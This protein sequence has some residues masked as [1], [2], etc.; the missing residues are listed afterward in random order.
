M[1]DLALAIDS[2][3][4]GVLVIHGD[5]RIARA[6]AGAE[7]LLGAAPGTLA[8]QGLAQLMQG[9][10]SDTV[11]QQT[12]R[13]LARP[14]TLPA[15][16]G[17]ALIR[18][19][20]GRPI[21]L[22]VVANALTGIPGQAGDALV[23]L[24]DVT[25]A[26]ARETLQQK[27]LEAMVRDLPL[28][29]VMTMVCVELERIAP[30]VI[31]S[32]LDV[33]AE[34]RLH[35]LAGPSLP[36]YYAEALDGI[37]CGPTVGSCG[38]S[39][40][41]GE[42]VLV[43]DIANDPLWAP[44]KGLV[45]PLGLRACWS[46]PIKGSDGRVLGTFAFYFRE[47]RGPDEF[48]QRLVDISV[49]LCALS[50]ERTRASARI[51]QLVTCDA[52]TGLPNRATLQADAEGL[53]ATMRREAAGLAT[54]VIGLDR[55][56]LVN[57]LQG[58]EA[59]DALLAESARRLQAEIRG[60]DAIARLA[61]DEFAVLLPRCTTEQAEQAATR[62]LASLARPIELAGITL[63][64]S[65]SVGIAMF[66]EDGD[67][68]DALLSEAAMAMHQAKREARGST[69]LFRPE[70][71]QR[72]KEQLTLER[73]LRDALRSGGLRL[74]YQ[75]QLSLHDGSGLYGVEALSR[76]HHAELGEVSPARFV[77]LAEE[78]GLSGELG[79]WVLDEACRQMADWRS[80]GIEVP[81]VAVN[82]SALDFRDPSLPDRVAHAL[83]RHG[84]PASALTLEMTETVMLDTTPESLSIIL[85]VDALGVHL[86]L[87]DF[88]TGYSS[89]SHLHRLPIDEIKLDRSFVRD[90][91][92]GASAR[93]LAGT[94]LSIGDSMGL[95]VVAEGVETE[96]QRDFLIER[97]CSVLQGFL[98]AR[99]MEPGALEH[100]LAGATAMA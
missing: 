86:S 78:C 92:A 28:P 72:A 76:W 30:E 46:S 8:G 52:L 59:G 24:T 21:W 82:L 31:A 5:G 54:L 67:R 75:P 45:L 81:R 49:H 2:S 65:A 53:L 66:P 80:R 89:L 43:S 90:L 4:S 57:D 1:T 95:T 11:T 100:W 79:R 26:K 99:P 73:A 63:T 27:A 34:G 18:A 7:R 88:G 39:A 56:R 93:A 15:Y 14:D 40:W 35:V 13:Y 25:L 98:L 69:R 47:P 74:N 3:D 32:I 64:P 91:P 33:D 16:R 62:M 17:E 10:T 58:R 50:M 22:S 61:G 41:R 83:S 42:P 23:V 94:V 84:V 77:A 48:H 44:Y 85:A 71:N 60:G 87:D 19:A 96:A 29:E 20:A 70:M 6:N 55:F 36:A 37:V 51:R 38:T 97:G 68:A 12:M 9:D